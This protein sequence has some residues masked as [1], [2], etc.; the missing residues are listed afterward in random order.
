MLFLILYPLC[1]SHLSACICAWNIG[2]DLK[3]FLARLRMSSLADSDD[4]RTTSFNPPLFIKSCAF[5]SARAI[6]WWSGGGDPNILRKTWKE[7]RR[8]GL[9]EMKMSIRL[10]F[11][12]GNTYVQ[13]TT[14]W[15][16]HWCRY[17]IVSSFGYLIFS[18]INSYTTAVL[19]SA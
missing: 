15:R 5:S 2:L 4:I 6:L 12:H 13:T 18:L 1:H 19:Q 3:V 10:C 7:E 14:T 11:A 8:S 9:D 16:V 17:V